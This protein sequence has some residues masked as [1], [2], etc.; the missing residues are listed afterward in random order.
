MKTIGMFVASI[1]LF[2]LTCATPLFPS[3]LG[4][5]DA[6]F[7]HDVNVLDHMSCVS[8]YTDIQFTKDI[9][10]IGN[11]ICA[12]SFRLCHKINL[13]SLRTSWTNGIIPFSVKDILGNIDLPEFLVG[14]LDA[15]RVRVLVEF[16]TDR[17]S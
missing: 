1:L 13:A 3:E 15:F 9:R 14:Y 16:T 5:R 8:Y 12:G 4:I 7:A 10:E 6:D 17:Q 11:M 2:G